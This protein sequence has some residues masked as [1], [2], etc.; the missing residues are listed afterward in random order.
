MSF[1]S[2]PCFEYFSTINK[3]RDEETV[4]FVLNEG[5]LV[6]KHILTNKTFN[7]NV[8]VHSFNMPYQV[9]VVPRT[10]I[11]LLTL[12]LDSR[13]LHDYFQ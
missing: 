2:A 7:L 12:E 8:S 4:S 10:I 11:T 13:P 1:E 3:S 5:K 9:A 6:S